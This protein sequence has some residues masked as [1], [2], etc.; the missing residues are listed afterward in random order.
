MSI[1]WNRF[2]PLLLGLLI[3]ILL[4]CREKPQL[5]ATYDLGAFANINP[6]AVCIDRKNGCIW[7]ADDCGKKHPTILHKILF[8]DL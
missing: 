3:A 1:R 2:S 7:V 5:L 6:E 4:G 8:S